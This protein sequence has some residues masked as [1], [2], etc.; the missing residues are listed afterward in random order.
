MA[1]WVTF[2]APDSR[3]PLRCNDKNIRLDV[4][5][6]ERPDTAARKEKRLS[7]GA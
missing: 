7:R 1:E 6:V 2:H 5:P 3:I 4:G